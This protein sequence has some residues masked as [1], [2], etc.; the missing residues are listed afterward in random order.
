VNLD[1]AVGTCQRLNLCE[2]YNLIDMIKDNS[3]LDYQ[4]IAEAAN[5]NQTA[6]TATT[7]TRFTDKTIGEVKKSHGTIVDPDWIIKASHNVE[8]Q[9][10]GA[11]IPTEFDSRTQWPECDSVINNIRD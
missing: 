2:S 5:S 4:A 1:D 9:P 10:V 8:Y 3:F 7:A 11:T 6:W